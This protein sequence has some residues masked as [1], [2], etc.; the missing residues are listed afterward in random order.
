MI[1]TLIIIIL[2]YSLVLL[3][4]TIDKLPNGDWIMWINWNN[5]RIFIMFKEN[6]FK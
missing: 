5:E 2:T 1:I 4:P 6:K 3:S